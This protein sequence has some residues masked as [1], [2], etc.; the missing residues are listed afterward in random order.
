MPR[1]SEIFW[2]QTGLLGY[3]T[4]HLRS[5]LVAIVKGENDVRPTGTREYS[6]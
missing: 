4:Q 1:S 5:D 6:M 3:A 2:S